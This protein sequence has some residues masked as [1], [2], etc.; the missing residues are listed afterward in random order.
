[1]GVDG[2]VGAV[3]CCR[4]MMLRVG[5]ISALRLMFERCCLYL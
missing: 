3:V 4:A 5:F 1:M 2:R